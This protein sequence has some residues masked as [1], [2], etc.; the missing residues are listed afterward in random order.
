MELSSLPSGNGFGAGVGLGRMAAGSADFYRCLSQG[1]Q[2]SSVTAMRMRGGSR[3][4]TGLYEA[5]FSEKCRDMHSRTGIREVVLGI[6][7]GRGLLRWD[8]FGRAK[9]GEGHGKHP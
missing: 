6:R 3:G 2:L 9:L 5:N 7:F 1:P 4:Q 8:E